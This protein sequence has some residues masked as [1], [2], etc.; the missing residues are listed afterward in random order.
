MVMDLGQALDPRELVPGNPAGI[1][2]VAGRLYNYAT[3]LNEAG[4]G[5]ERIETESGWRGAAADAFRAR[6]RGEPGKW[7]EAGSCFLAAARALDDYVPVLEWGQREAA[8][9]VTQWHAGNHQAAQQILDSARS[10]VAGAAGET[11]AIIGRARDQAPQKPGFWSEVGGFL[12]GALHGA[13]NV[14]ADVLNG[15]ASFGNAMI[16]HPGDTGTML[17]GALLMGVGAL[18]DAGGAVLDASGVGAVI[19]IPANVVSTGA[20]V[21]GATMMAASGG[22]LARHAA[23]DDSVDPVKTGGDGGSPPQDPRLIP[24]TPEYDS[25]TSDLAKD[26][27]QGGNV[28]DKTMREATVGVQAEADGDIPGPLTRAPF[29]EAGK[30]VGEFTDSTGQNWDV[31]SSPSVQPDYGNNPGQPIK[32]QT[33]ASFTRM[34]NKELGQG[35]KVLLDPHA[36][37]AE[38]LAHLQELVAG[39]P[40]WEG[41]VVWGR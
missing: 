9:A 3:L 6:F 32:V 10:R 2:A 13:E 12:E 16:N 28:S 17:G 38:R 23:G 20:I 7:L 31:K 26:P 36:M 30:D 14:G 15:A 11:A 21:S 25:Y 22:D 18:G 35:I 29:N 40:E 34:I 19:G 8:E 27:A 5:L 4:N 33:D 39:N 24:G 1:A 41:K 37:S